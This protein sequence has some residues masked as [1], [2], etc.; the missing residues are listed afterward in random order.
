MG[1]FLQLSTVI[2]ICLVCNIL[3]KNCVPC[4]F[5]LQLWFIH[6]GRVRLRDRYGPHEIL[7]SV[8]PDQ[9]TSIQFHNLSH[10]PLGLSVGLGQCKHIVT[11]K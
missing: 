3:T 7:L 6:I 2:T 5:I 1:E 10:L 4:T 8:G 11:P 9:F